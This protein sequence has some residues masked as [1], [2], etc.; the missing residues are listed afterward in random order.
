MAEGPIN[1]LWNYNVVG[2]SW[3]KS[4]KPTIPWPTRVC[5]PR[6]EDLT[7]LLKMSFRLGTRKSL[8]PDSA[9]D[10]VPLGKPRHLS[11]PHSVHSVRRAFAHRTVLSQR[12]SELSSSQ[13]LWKQCG[14]KFKGGLLPLVPL[15]SLPGHT[16]S[17]PLRHT[18]LARASRSWAAP[19]T[20]YQ[21]PCWNRCPLDLT[22]PPDP[23]CLSGSL[24]EPWPAFTTAHF[25]GFVIKKFGDQASVKS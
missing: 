15:E 17:G 1:A 20:S 19:G 9:T 18:K 16:P 12:S 21:H 10:C 7:H 4:F 14:A 24:R 6:L 23:P 22:S 25:P 5:I 13:A 2:W 3:W 8:S 11:G